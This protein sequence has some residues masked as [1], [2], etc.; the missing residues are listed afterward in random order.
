MSGQPILPEKA[1][2]V[3]MIF[4]FKVKYDA[5]IRSFCKQYKQTLVMS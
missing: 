5:G 2:A 4:I 3:E 1:S